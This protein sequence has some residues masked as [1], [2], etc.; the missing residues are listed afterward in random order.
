MPLGLRINKAQAIVP[1]KEDFQ[2]A[3]RTN[4][5]TVARIRSNNRKDPAWGR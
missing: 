3:E 2:V 5:A 1:V 4:R